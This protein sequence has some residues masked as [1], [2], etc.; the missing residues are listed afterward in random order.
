MIKKHQRAVYPDHV[1]R[2]RLDWWV[3]LIAVTFLL[4]TAFSIPMVIWYGN[5]SAAVTVL[6]VVLLIWFVVYTTDI[7]FYG[8]YILE[9]DALLVSSN[10]RVAVVPYVNIISVKPQGVVSLFSLGGRKRY[11]L[12][13]HALELKLKN[14]HWRSITVSPFE[15]DRFLKLLLDRIETA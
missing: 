12:S 11:S 8:V 14:Y 6:F 7:V 4:L 15:K 9:E 2:P 10:F 3:G 5:L 13:R 1:F